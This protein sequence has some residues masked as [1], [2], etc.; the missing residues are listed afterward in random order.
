M[1]PHFIKI[2]YFQIPFFKY[3][4]F[5][6][7]NKQDSSLLLINIYFTMLINV[8]FCMKFMTLQTFY[9]PYNFSQKCKI[10]CVSDTKFRIFYT[11]TNIEYKSFVCL[12]FLVLQKALFQY[13]F[14]FLFEVCKNTC[15]EGIGVKFGNLKETMSSEAICTLISLLF[16]N[17]LYRLLSSTVL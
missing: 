16:Q 17:I 14:L 5:L 6:N 1:A 7:R 4:Y 3:Y 10:C 2:I 8:Y 13:K 12:S 11:V 9:R 15:P